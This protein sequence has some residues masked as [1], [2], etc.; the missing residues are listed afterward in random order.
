MF[1]TDLPYEYVVLQQLASCMVMDV[2]GEEANGR[3]PRPG[4]NKCTAGRPGIFP[5]LPIALLL[6]LSIHESEQDPKIHRSDRHWG[7][8]CPHLDTFA[9]HACVELAFMSCAARQCGLGTCA[10]STSA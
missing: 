10:T 1:Y 2:S 8:V 5:S 3:R 4:Q 9:G 6:Y 7:K